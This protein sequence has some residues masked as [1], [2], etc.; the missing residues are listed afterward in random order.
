MLTGLLTLLAASQD[1]FESL[2]PWVDVNYAQGALFNGTPTGEEWAN[3]G[4]T[5]V[6]WLVIPLAVGLRYVMRSEVK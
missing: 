5:G 2:R 4:V 3:I 6:F 1:W